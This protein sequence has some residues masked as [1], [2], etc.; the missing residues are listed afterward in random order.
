VAQSA[1]IIIATFILL[2]ST[3]LLLVLKKFYVFYINLGKIYC[4]IFGV[5]LMSELLANIL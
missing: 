5:L 1:E 3:D 2:I 4:R